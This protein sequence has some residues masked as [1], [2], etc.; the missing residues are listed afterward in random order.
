MN[1]APDPSSLQRPDFKVPDRWASSS[2]VTNPMRGLD[3]RILVL[4]DLGTNGPLSR[5]RVP[6]ADAGKLVSVAPLMAAARPHLRLEL[7]GAGAGA[8]EPAPLEQYYES[9]EC[10]KHRHINQ[11]DCLG[12]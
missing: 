1:A 9:V 2:E 3:H 10:T 4:S 5:L 6:G 12:G 11:R 8:G 7:P